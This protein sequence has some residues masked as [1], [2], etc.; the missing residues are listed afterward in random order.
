MV[1]LF[2]IKNNFKFFFSMDG[3]MTIIVLIVNFSIYNFALYV[4][5]QIE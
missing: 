2:L 1:I 5:K 4:K 3:I